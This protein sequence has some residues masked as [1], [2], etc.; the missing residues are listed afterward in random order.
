[1]RAWI[2]N[3]DNSLQSC[4]GDLRESLMVKSG[5]RIT[6]RLKNQRPVHLALLPSILTEFKFVAQQQEK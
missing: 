4:I 6:S 3:S 5:G 1:M 2:I